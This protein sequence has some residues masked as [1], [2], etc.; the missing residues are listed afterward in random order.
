MRIFFL[1]HLL[2][3][4]LLILVIGQ[5]EKQKS[6]TRTWKE[7]I[8]IL[9]V[10]DVSESM[11]ATDFTPN[12][13]EVAKSVIRDFIRVRT[14][15][16]IGLVIFAGE[17]VTKCP[18]THDYDFL[19][20]QLEDIRLGELKQGTAIGM[21]IATGVARLHT[22]EPRTKVMILLTDGDNN[23]GSIN[24]LTA[25]GLARQSQIKIYSIGIGKSDRVVVPIYAYDMFGKRTQP[26]AQVPSYL[27]PELLLGISQTTA[28]HAFMARDPGALGKVLHEIDKL[29]K[30]KIQSTTVRESEPRYLALAWIATVLATVLFIFRQTR[31][32]FASAGVTKL[33]GLH[34]EI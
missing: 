8:D 7:G 12:R 32:R 34:A 3:I 23:V 29:E 33:R 19:Q 22:S 17:A 15:D 9:L 2:V 16:R 24:P 25:A 21:A 31:F 4:G 18:L 28:G 20:R 26:I 10:L 14:G 5:P 1:G 6:W 30:T 11:D 13:I 27:N